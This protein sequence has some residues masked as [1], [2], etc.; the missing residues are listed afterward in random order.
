VAA[1]EDIRKAA[2]GH[3]A[4]DGEMLRFV[5]RTLDELA[6]KSNVHPGSIA[7]P[8]GKSEKQQPQSSYAVV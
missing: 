1:K 2:L 3:N 7:T 8:A 5:V 6:L 4:T